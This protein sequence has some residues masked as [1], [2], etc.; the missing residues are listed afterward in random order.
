M[1]KEL[2][3]ITDLTI[4]DLLNN[5]VILPSTYF[6]KFS[7][8]A[9]GLEI[10]LENESYQKE[11]NKVIIE[12]FNN[13][14]K[15]MSLIIS[16]ASDLQK[17]TQTAK[18]AILNKDSDTLNDVYKKMILLENEIKTLTNKLFI[19][20]ITDTYNRKWIYNSF[21]DKDSS[22]KEDGICVLVDVI[23][24]SYLQKE[25]GEL[26]ANNLLIFATN[27]ISKKLSEE[28]YDFKIARYVENKFFIFISDEKKQDI[29]NTILN[30]EQLLLATTLKSNSGLLI[31][32]KYQ[33]KIKEFKQKKSSKSILEDL[34][35]QEKD[36]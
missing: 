25:Y 34:L 24:Y 32:A 15:Y 18:T 12:D 9:K 35:A 22:F 23:D 33:F 13:I 28:K 30:I 10:N 2:K 27:F 19:D 5:E 29:K 8:H 11:L 21:L 16:N 20:D 1:R 7:Y 26:L 3:K 31:K 17:N 36:R 6:D 4:N 14:E